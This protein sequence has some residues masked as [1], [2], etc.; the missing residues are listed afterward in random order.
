MKTRLMLLNL[1][2]LLV[3]GCGNKKESADK[4]VNVDSNQKKTTRLIAFSKSNF[5]SENDNTKLF[6]TE[7]SKYYPEKY[8]CSTP[9]DSVIRGDINQDG[10]E[11]ILFRYSV[12]DIENRTWVACGWFIAFSDK[13]KNYNEYIFY[14]W[15]SG[16]GAPTQL[17][18]GFPTSINNGIIY[19][20]IDDYNEDDA[21][22]CPS[23]KRE[24]SF[25][26]D[27]ELALMSLTNIK[28]LN[29]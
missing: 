12:D 6:L 10:Y 19:S 25:L 5:K 2:A 16:Q 4:D 28:T 17:D 23:I 20:N 11:D 8:E 18:Y 14:D 1:S 15:S 29:N 7:L 26:F 21:S 9:D 24:M 13:E 27:K 3:I 22:C